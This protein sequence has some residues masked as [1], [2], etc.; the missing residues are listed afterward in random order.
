MYGDIRIA[1]NVTIGANSVVNHSF[2]KEGAVIAGSPA[3]II[4]EDVTPWVKWLLP[5]IDE[6][7]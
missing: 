1:N 4:N 6:K 5:T 3:K 2:E 7:Q